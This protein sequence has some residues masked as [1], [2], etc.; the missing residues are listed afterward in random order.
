MTFDPLPPGQLWDVRKGD[1]LREM[2]LLPTGCVDLVICSPPYETARTYGTDMPWGRRHEWAKWSARRFME[3]CRLSR[4][5]VAWVVGHGMGGTRAW[6]AAPALLIAELDAMGMCL[7]NPP[8]YKRV[9]IPGSGQ[10]DWLRA[11]FEWIVCGTWEAK[12]LPWSDNTAMGHPPKWAPGGEMSARLSDGTRRNQWGASPNGRSTRERRRN[13][14]RNLEDQVKPSHFVVSKDTPF[15]NRPSE[16]C[17]RETDKR[18]YFNGKRSKRLGSENLKGSIAGP[19]WERGDNSVK[20]A[21]ENNICVIANPGNVI[22]GTVG[23]NQMGHPIASENEAPY[24]LWIPEFFIRS[25]CP[26]G[27]LVLDPF[28][29]SGST[30][31]A[32]VIHGRRG[33]G[34]DIR[35]SEIRKTRRRMHDIA[36]LFDGVGSG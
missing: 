2:M 28:V 26:P 9:S 15:G 4:G 11:D 12:R 24:P 23:G 5:L 18:T 8:I 33:L 3:C 29:G 22:S 14:T 19:G 31:H 27:G 7:R 17:G 10:D 6:T 1:C 34:F 30:L 25:F 32:A 20:G 36:P 13:G 35:E 21:H 16:A